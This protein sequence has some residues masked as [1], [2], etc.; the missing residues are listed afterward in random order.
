M[1]P[2]FLQGN[3]EYWRGSDGNWYRHVT[4][5]VKF[6]KAREICAG[7]FPGARVMAIK[8]QETA[9]F[10][11]KFIKDTG[12]NGI[13]YWVGATDRVQEGNFQWI[14]GYGDYENITVT[15]WVNGKPS[16]IGGDKNCVVTR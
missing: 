4:E 15:R 7:D 14:D 12:V 10:L 6:D 8:S 11:E 1:S 5:K 16:K 3:C 13:R 9:D 2:N